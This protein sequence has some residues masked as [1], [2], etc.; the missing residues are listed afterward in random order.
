MPYRF[1][2]VFIILF[3]SHSIKSQSVINDCGT[4]LSLSAE[5]KVNDKISVNGK[6]QARVVENFLLFNRI[7]FRLG[8]DYDMNTNLTFNISGNYIQSRGGFYEMSPSYRYSV[9][10]TYKRK[11]TERF[12]ASNK[13]MW[14]NTADHIINSDWVKQKNSGVIRDKITLKFKINRRGSVYITEELLWQLSGKKEKYFGR[15]RVYAGYSYKINAKLTLE[16]Y[17]IIEQS[18]NRLSGPQNRNFL[19]CADLKYSF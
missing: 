10:A 15:N 6:I 5:K 3:L 17:F 4:R 18:Y 13:L 7:Y 2:I 16:P 11:L 19:Y 9:A 12:S 1:F 14:Q 8:L